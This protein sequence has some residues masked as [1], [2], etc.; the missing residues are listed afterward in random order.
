MR[1]DDTEY[2]GGT[3]DENERHHH[4]GV[5]LIDD[6]EGNGLLAEFNFALSLDG[7][8]KWLDD[9]EEGGGF[10]TAARRTRGGSNEDND[11]EDDD[12]EGDDF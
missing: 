2:D 10:D 12:D 4:D 11:D 8:E 1:I 3:D 7:G 9:D 5:G 6:L